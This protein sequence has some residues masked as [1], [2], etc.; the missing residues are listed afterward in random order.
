MHN[1]VGGLPVRPLALAMDWHALWTVKALTSFFQVETL[2]CYRRRLINARTHW[3]WT[4]V[5]CNA[6]TANGSARGE[7]DPAIENGML[8]DEF[9]IQVL[10]AMDAG[11]REIILATGMELGMALLR[12]QDPDQ[13][14]DRM[15]SMV[16]DGYVQ[17]MA[18]SRA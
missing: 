13:L 11:K 14:F 16:R 15:S 5:S 3:F 6:V 17:K 18:A 4:N 9:A 7:S 2:R 10:A 12:R 1:N 8:P